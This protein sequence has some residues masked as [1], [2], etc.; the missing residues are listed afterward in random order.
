MQKHVNAPV[1]VNT[2]AEIDLHR[3]RQN[4]RRIVE[5]VRPVDVVA[6][7]KADAYGHGLEETVR[8]VRHEGL[9]WFAVGSLAEGI[10]LRQM[11]SD[12]CA[13]IVFAAPAKTNVGLYA[14]HRLDILVSSPQ[15]ARAV[16][17]Y[18][19]RTTLRAHVKVDT[20]MGRIG[21]QPSDLTDLAA[22]LRGLDHVELIGVATHL[23]TADDDDLGVTLGQMAVFDRAL[24]EAGL[25]DTH[26]HVANSE[27]L[28]RIPT[29]LRAYDRPL[30]RLG[31]AM[32]GC[33]ER[34]DTREKLG[35]Q[36]AMRLLSRIVHV[37]TVEAGTPISYGHRWRSSR[38][39]R[40]A[41]LGTGYGDGYPRILTNRAR[42]GIHGRLFPVVGT[43]C[44][45]MTMVDVGPDTPDGIEVRPGDV[46][47]LFGDGGPDVSEV[48]TWAETISYEICTGISNRVPK[49]YTRK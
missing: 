21:I 46:A 25:E 2:W 14:E 12:E 22:R 27:A 17:E 29:S 5:H 9:N 40:I 10:V 36:P 7:V 6:V 39:T 1:T 35:L 38:R 8:A 20:G 45:D 32:Y 3:I 48:A 4:V 23:A 26:V 49:L 16:I 30:G 13:I 28:I 11:L 18:D 47:V 24:R 43:V 31:I 19:G 34:N 41:T 44:M 15:A 37:K 42:V 33:P